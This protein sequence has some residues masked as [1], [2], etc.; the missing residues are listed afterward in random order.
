MSLRDPSREHGP[1]GEPAED[2]GAQDR[3]A[4]DE[5]IEIV[6][7]VAN[8][9]EECQQLKTELESQ[10]FSVM[11]REP[12]RL[13]AEGENY[14]ATLFAEKREPVM[15]DTWAVEQEKLRQKKRDRKIDITA[16]VGFWIAVGLALLGVLFLCGPL[17]RA[18]RA[19]F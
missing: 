17:I 12:T 11:V 8:S 19:L 9:R 15:V 7:K 18:Y 10:G 6:R 5:K 4:P 13:D 2:H 16:K 3:F 1:L 14:V